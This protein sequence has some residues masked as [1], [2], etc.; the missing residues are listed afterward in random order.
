[1]VRA[2]ITE[3][4]KRDR[5]LFWFG[6]FNI[7]LLALALVM[8]G[9]D[10][11]LIKGIN[12]WIKPMKFAI[13]IAVYSWTFGWLLHYNIQEK[14]NR[15]IRA[16]VV[17]TMLVEVVLIYM[18]AF[19]GTTSHFN[20]YSAFDGIVFGVMGIFI[21]INSVI[22]F[23]TIIVFFTKGITLD[24]AALWA[25]R[26]GLILFFLGG[27]SG[28]WMVSQ[29][30]HT[31]GAADGGPGLPFVNWST[32]A[33]DIRAAHFV[34]LH[35]LQALPLATYLFTITFKESAKT[36]SIT[37]ITLYCILC[38]YLHMLA[39]KGLPVLSY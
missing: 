39:S 18:Q 29:L 38:V 5:V 3:L 35:G 17:V 19:R 1:M 31:V 12:A 15:V 13:S 6:W 9:V 34:T 7:A 2:F 24:G 23:Y 16:G 11:T 27:I 8:Y 14:A 32:V 21:G 4:K 36:W 25:W 20:V 28:G 10:D 22:N 30:A 37:F 26:C 33:G